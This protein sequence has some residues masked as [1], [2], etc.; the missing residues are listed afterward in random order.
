MATDNT[1]ETTAPASYTQKAVETATSVAQGVA[2]RVDPYVPQVA[3]S[4]ASFAANTALSAG[5]F[6]YKTTTATLDT[7]TKAIV[8]TVDFASSTA[9]AAKD[10]AISTA[11]GVVNTGV[12]TATGVVNYSIDKATWAVNGTTSTITAYTPGPVLSLV[13]NTLAGANALSSDPVGTLKPY[14]P[15]FVIHTGERTYE[16]VE[17]TTEKTKEG[18]NAT[19]GFIVTKVNGTVK[20]VTDIPQVQALIDKLNA[21]AGPVLNR[22]RIT[23]IE[24][25]AAEAEAEVAAANAVSEE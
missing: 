15:T 3:K 17:K 8:S 9:T 18:I 25:P 13:N 2:A 4:A 14:V 12:R 24:A 11:T 5:D 21:I 6:A 7:T 10:A 23:R 20:M 1:T 19:T 22:L 16:I